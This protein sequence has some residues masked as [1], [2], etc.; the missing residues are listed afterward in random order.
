MEKFLKSTTFELEF[1]D[2][3]TERGRYSPRFIDEI[4]GEIDIVEDRKD[5]LFSKLICSKYQI[6]VMAFFDCKLHFNNNN[7]ISRIFNFEI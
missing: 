4:A 5:S 2:D 3:V 7:V 6:S 1:N